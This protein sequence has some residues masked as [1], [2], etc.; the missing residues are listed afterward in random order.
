MPSKSNI[1][2]SQYSAMSTSA[3]RFPPI[4]GI[5]EDIPPE[6]EE[7]YIEVSKRIDFRNTPKV[8]DNRTFE[9]VMIEVR[10][11][12]P[13]TRGNTNASEALILKEVIAYL[14]ETWPERCILL[15]ERRIMLKE[16]RIMLKAIK[17]RPRMGKL[18]RCKRKVHKVGLYSNCSVCGLRR[19]A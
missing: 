9:D 10:D 14:D 11:R 13:N 1:A 8:S 5:I 12:V 6:I 17:Q 16:C 2:K 19:R 4:A 7:L 18:K 3:C 15:K